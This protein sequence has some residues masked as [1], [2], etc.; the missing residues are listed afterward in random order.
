[1]STGALLRTGG[2]G[3]QGSDSELGNY[4]LPCPWP[5]AGALPAEALRATAATVHRPI[6]Q[7]MDPKAKS[8]RND[9]SNENL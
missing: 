4:L 9:H 5:A 2:G 3:I 1:M 7:E 8:W 6:R